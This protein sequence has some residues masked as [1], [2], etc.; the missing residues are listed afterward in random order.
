VKVAETAIKPFHAAGFE[1]LVKRW[2]MCMNIGGEY[3]EKK[4]IFPGSDI[5]CFT[6]YINL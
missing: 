1:A 6:F 3:I 2:G 4:M 5:T